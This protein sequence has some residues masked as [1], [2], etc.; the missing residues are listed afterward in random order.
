MLAL[1]TDLC[2]SKIHL[3]TCS[4]VLFS[5][6]GQQPLLFLIT[7]GAG[8]WALVNLNCR[9]HSRFYD[10][11]SVLGCCLSPR[12]TLC[13]V[14]QHIPPQASH[15]TI[16]QTTRTRENKNICP[17]LI[18]AFGILAEKHNNE[19]PKS[20]DFDTGTRICRPHANNL[21]SAGIH[22]QSLFYIRGKQFTQLVECKGLVSHTQ[23]CSP[24]RT[25]KS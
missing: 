23:Y 1:C 17:E 10:I 11:S 12:Q 15:P 5:A 14:V 21:Q 24:C 8:V 4:E 7:P 13:T 9:E 25:E 6:A 18:L 3:V 22:I 16:K 20:R 2:D 19:P